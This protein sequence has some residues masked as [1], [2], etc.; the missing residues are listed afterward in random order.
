VRADLHTHSSASDGTDPPAQ[1]MRRARAAG[2]DVVALTDHD[3]LAGQDE[4]RRALPAGLSLVPGMELSCRLAG[5]SVHLLAYRTDPAN[6]ELAA[7]TAAIVAG[8]V[9]RGRA[10]VARLREL[11]VDVSW[12]QVQA[13]AGGGVVGRPHIARAMVAAGAISEPAQA[14]TQEWIG[15]GGRAYVSRFAL[16][17]ADAIRQVRRAGG[18][19]VLAHPRA[20]TRGWQIGEDHI[21]ALAAAGL[22]GLEVDH[23]DHDQAKRRRL[24]A[25]AAELDLVVTGGSDDHGALTGYR[26]GCETTG[27]AAYERLMSL[28]APAAP[29]GPPAGDS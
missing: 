21:A 10:M 1:V 9:R 16:D 17:P 20:A 23:P 4:A 6:A 5:H 15:P 18:V 26:I 11:G 13:I 28:C 19:A 14:F 27:P 24:R 8:R 29:A 12:P 22:A 7:S 25:L 3:V 2:L